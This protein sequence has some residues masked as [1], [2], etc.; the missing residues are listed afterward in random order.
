[1]AVQQGWIVP[2]RRPQVVLDESGAVVKKPNGAPEL[3]WRS[4]IERRHVAHEVRYSTEGPRVEERLTEEGQQV[5]VWQP[6][7]SARESQVAASAGALRVKELR[8]QS[9]LT[10]EGLFWLLSKLVENFMNFAPLG[11]VLVGMLGIGVAERV[12]LLGAVLK[13]FMMVVPGRLLTPAMVFLGIMS[14]LGIDAGYVVLPPLAA[15][16]YKAAG[17]SPLAGLAAVFAG[18]AAG[19][20]A[21]LF[22]TGLDPMLAELTKKGA[23]V[24]DAG[25]AV[26]PACNWWFMI[27]STIL[28]TLS[29]W[30]V[31]ARF[32][33]RRLAS[34][35]A[36]EGGPALATAE[37]LAQQRLT[38]RE[39][40]ALLF[41]ALVFGGAVT[42]FV[43]SYRTEGS[44]LY[45]AGEH[46]Q[47]WAEAI[48][49]ML[50]LL[51]L[52]PALAYG[53]VMGKVKG[54]KSVAKL[55]IESIA[56][57]API[58]VLAFFAAQFIEAF[59]F[60]GLD[61]MLAEWGGQYLGQA[62]MSKP[63]LVIA[64]IG[65]TIVFNLFIGSMSAKYTMFAPIFVPMFM[66]VG[67]SP[68]LTQAAYRVGDSVSNTITPLNPYLII[69][70]VFMR[71][72][73]P[74][75]G[76][77]TLI[78]TMLPYTIAFTIVWVALLVV[79]MLLGQPLG[80]DGA[81]A[82]RIGG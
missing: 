40:A 46:F 22:I 23:Q 63:L 77:G 12:G 49:P 60:S 29:G 55:L 37:E 43:W 13:A 75:A 36:E 39:L 58:I 71:R 41:A 76:M 5:V 19:F 16:L 30:L 52:L 24:V 82:Y 26:N 72:F 79:W 80:P 70:L 25:Y 17:R 14:S 9:L 48:V 32:V 57:M 38:T 51:F 34:K 20:N 8:P 73:V 10:S 31:T 65:V 45:G 74:K 69:I 59:K 27:A 2:E 66:L 3:E 47:R 33:E 50:F 28:I 64:F 61:R 67:I 7:A 44:A 53:L 18:V 54:D 68:E 1:V 35:S 42:V 62:E 78:A 6:D 81:L 15:A 21:N 11:V 4:T 56:A